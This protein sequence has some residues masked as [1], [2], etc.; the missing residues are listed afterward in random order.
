MKPPEES[1]S[2]TSIGKLPADVI[3]LILTFLPI[4]QAVRTSILSTQ[5]RHRWRRIP[6]LVFDEDF[7]TIS[8][9]S[10]VMLEIYQA[11]LGHEGPVN[12]F[13]LAIPGMSLCPQV[14]QLIHYLSTKNVKELSLVIPEAEETSYN[15]DMVT[16]F[17]SLPALEELNVG[18]ELL[19]GHVPYQLPQSLHNLKVLEAPRILLG[20]LTEAQVLL[21]LIRSSPNLQK[22]TIVHD[23][24]LYRPVL[25][26][27]D[28]LQMLLEHSHHFGVSCLQRL[29]EF[30]IKNTRGT[31]VEQDL[32][33]FVLATALINVGRVWRIY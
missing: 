14:H 17:A 19:L 23:D 3:C 28:S 10:K 22:L 33:K 31:R 16:L 8:A 11:L 26:S 27:I 5:W 9:N 4:K 30:D 2:N 15:P 6:Q 7:A 29:E 18:F 20:R 13:E 1:A 25:M 21:C 12:K 32:L 24:D